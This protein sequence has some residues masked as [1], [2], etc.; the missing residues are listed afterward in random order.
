ML[1]IYDDKLTV[2]KLSELLKNQ[3][4]D[5]IVCIIDA[6][7]VRSVRSCF[8]SERDGQEAIILCTR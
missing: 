5:T 3:A 6:G 8:Y 7:N 1:N 4:P 2:E